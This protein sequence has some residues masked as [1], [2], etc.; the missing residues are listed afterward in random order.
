[1]SKKD[2][3]DP[4]N[5]VRYRIDLSHPM[6]SVDGEPEMMFKQESGVLVPDLDKTGQQKVWT[7]QEAFRVLYA[8]G[9]K[10]QL[11]L[12]NRKQWKDTLRKLCRQNIASEPEAILFESDRN[13]LLDRCKPEHACWKTPVGNGQFHNNEVWTVEAQIQVYRALDNAEKIDDE[14]KPEPEKPLEN[15][16][17]SNP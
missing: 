1:V 14:P 5:P 15:A 8:A 9:H 3:S 13:W 10:M 16:C 4:I 2:K 12:D 17:P 7:L 11:N 6:Y